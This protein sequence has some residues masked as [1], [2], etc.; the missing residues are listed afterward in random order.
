M[1]AWV[2]LLIDRKSVAGC[3]LGLLDLRAHKEV[4]WQCAVSIYSGS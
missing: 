1:H 3:H 2:Q 4:R